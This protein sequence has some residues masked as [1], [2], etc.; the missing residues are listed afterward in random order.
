MDKANTG[1]IGVGL[2]GHG[3][4]KNLL[5]KGHPL[6]VM[7]HRNRA[8]VEDLI[9]RG[10]TEAKT[11]REM[12]EAVDILHICVSGSPEV[13]GVI[14][15]PDGILA[16]G[17]AG[18][19]VIDCST[20]DPVSTLQLADELAAAGMILV[21]AP[22]ARTP[23]EAEAGTLDTMVGADPE[24]FAAIRP[25]LAC[26]AANIVHLGPV[27]LGHKMK[28]INNFIAMGYGALYSEALAIARKSGL[29]AQQVDDVIRPGRLSNGFYE[30]FMKYTLERD[31][32]AH[33]FSIRNAAKDMRYLANLAL[34]VGAVN[35]VQGAVRNAFAGMEAEGE[36]DR[37]VPMLADFIAARNGLPPVDDA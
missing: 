10:A 22:L 31:E 8:P 36:G 34:A 11:P 3:I 20:S 18:L 14:R 37:Y 4:A 23:K 2:M 28:L 33:R 26:W 30:T 24:T 15:G 16:S 7:A 19:I 17:K 12:A 32:D 5:E 25:V 35:P 9:G 6:T 1:V 21:D 29:T 27:G 13:E